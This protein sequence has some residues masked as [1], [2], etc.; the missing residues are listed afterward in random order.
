MET[1]DGWSESF[2]TCFITLFWKKKKKQKKNK[3]KKHTKEKK[4]NKKKKKNTYT[5]TNL[6][7]LNWNFYRFKMP[8]LEEL[9]SLCTKLS[10]LG[11]HNY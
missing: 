6:H 11:Q 1:Y 8:S 10:P 3:K 5:N 9:H 4:K 7:W 2:E